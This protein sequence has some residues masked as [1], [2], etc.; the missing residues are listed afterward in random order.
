[1]DY[2]RDLTV[3]GLSMEQ[4]QRILKIFWEDDA[5]Y[6][7]LDTTIE[8]HQFAW[9]YNWDDGPEAP[10]WVIRHPQCDRGTALLIYWCASP[11]WNAQYANREEVPDYSYGPHWDLLRYDL[12]KEI[13][14]R[15]LSGFYTNQTISFD[16]TDY[17]G[18]DMT[19][20]YYHLEA[21]QE[22]PKIMYEPTPGIKLTQAHF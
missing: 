19:E 18:S 12:V 17:K 20:D 3:T 7:S 4:Y 2:I 15:Y 11:H 5:T 6:L 22:I 14:E 21:K 16:P 10:L 1:M 9:S 8:L 13:E